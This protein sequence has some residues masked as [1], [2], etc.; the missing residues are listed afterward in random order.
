MQIHFIAIGGSVMHQLAIALHRKS[1]TI[2][3]SDDVI[4]NPA[5]ANLETHG[6]LPTEEGWFVDKIHTDLD[7]VILGMHARKDNPELLRAQ[8]LG[9]PVY[10]Y[11]AYIYEQAKDKKRVVVGGSHGKTTITSMIMHVLA[12][13]KLDFDY[14]V[15]A[16]LENFDY[17]VKITAD[18]PIIVLEGDEY[19][20]SP[21]HRTPKFHFYQANV[22]ILSGIA[23]D[24]INV[25]PTYDFYLEQ[26]QHYVKSLADSAIFI[27]NQ[28]DEEVAKL[29]KDYTHMQQF[30]YQT[31]SYVETADHWLIRFEEQDYPLQVF[32]HHNL[33]NMEAARLAC[34]QLGVSGADFYRAM[35]E[36]KGA[37]RRLELLEETE[38]CAI[39]KDFA[40]APSKV[41]ATTL[42]VKQRFPNRRL[43]ACL[44]LHTYSSL[45]KAF[46]PHYHESLAAADE[47][48]VYYNKHTFEIKRLEMLDQQ[49][50]AAAFEHPNLRVITDTNELKDYL[51]RISLK[52]TNL[53][54]MS[55]GNY[56][57]I[58]VDTF[59]G[60]LLEV[61]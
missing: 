55:S 5:R 21:I 24:H 11:P 38:D 16:K 20:S 12:F 23:W 46:L 34:A 40:H 60:E 42:A 49:E 44:E 52:Q 25:F 32:G 41:K 14:L 43:V 30:A 45:S 47:A 54:L 61:R 36:F 17:S 39:Y 28:E 7:A 9:I 51:K 56:G 35:Q 50:V 10:S 59:A 22:A 19:L 53:L 29:A 18:A 57:G 37:A 8:E 6:L 48:I 26:F 27:Y 1:Y 2:T 33:Q 58:V 31:P 15:G 3:G 4:F 13:Q